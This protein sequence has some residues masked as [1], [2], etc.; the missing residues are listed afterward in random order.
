MPDRIDLKDNLLSGE[1]SGSISTAVSQNRA[2]D[3]QKVPSYRHFVEMMTGQILM[4]YGGLL[5][6]DIFS[7]V[8]R[9]TRITNPRSGEVRSPRTADVLLLLPTRSGVRVSAIQGFSVF[10]PVDQGYDS[11]NRPNLR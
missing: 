4:R 5:T 6:V 9:A 10:A 2:C 8:R 11:S 3:D 1:N 7:A